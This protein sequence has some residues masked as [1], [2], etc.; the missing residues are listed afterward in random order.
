MV[1]DVKYHIRVGYNSIIHKNNTARRMC[2]LYVD[3]YWR[4]SFGRSWIGRTYWI[5]NNDWKHNISVPLDYIWLIR[6]TQWW[7][8]TSPDFNK[9]TLWKRVIISWALSYHKD[10]NLKIPLSITQCRKFDGI[11][12]L[13]ITMVYA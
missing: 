7:L 8:S 13:W 3:F 11:I 1:H 12:Y 10:E 9:H 6:Y 2:P 5:S 4:C